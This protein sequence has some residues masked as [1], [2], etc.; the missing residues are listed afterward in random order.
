MPARRSALKSDNF[1]MAHGRLSTLVFSPLHIVIM[2]GGPDADPE[3]TSDAPIRDDPAVSAPS[4]KKLTH[5]EKEA[6]RTGWRAE[7]QSIP[8]QRSFGLVV[9]AL[10]MT[11]F[12]G[13]LDQVRLVSHSVSRCARN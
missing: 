7:V 8:K 13:A 3:K 5:E 2:A 9:F 11:V 4:G 12:L 10:L 1:G 6:A